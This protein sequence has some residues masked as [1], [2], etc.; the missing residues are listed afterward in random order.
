MHLFSYF[1]FDITETC[2]ECFFDC[3][4]LVQSD[5]QVLTAGVAREYLGLMLRYNE[6]G[7]EIDL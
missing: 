2:K 4:L 1:D 7:T 3:T 6:V 5:L